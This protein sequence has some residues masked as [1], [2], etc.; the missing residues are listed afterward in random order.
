MGTESAFFFF[1]K[2]KY[3]FHALDDYFL[4]IQDSY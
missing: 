2:V 4:K 1:F 3:N